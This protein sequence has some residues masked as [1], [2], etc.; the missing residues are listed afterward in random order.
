[1]VLEATLSVANEKTDRLDKRII[2]EDNVIVAEADVTQLGSL[3][4]RWLPTAGRETPTVRSV[5]VLAAEGTHDVYDYA[6]QSPGPDD[7]E[8]RRL[9]VHRILPHLDLVRPPLDELRH[10]HKT[11]DGKSYLISYWQRSHGGRRYVV[12]AWHSVPHVVHDLFPRMLE[13]T[14]GSARVHVVDEEGRTVFGQPTAGGEFTVGVPFQTTLYGWRLHATLTTAEELGVSVERRRRLEMIMVAASFLLVVAGVVIVVVAADRERRLAALKSELVANVSHE[15]KTPLSLVRMFSELLSSDRVLSETK[16]RQY[17]SII[18]R[19]SERLSAL[20]ENV[21]D[22]ARLERGEA[23]YIFEEASL[24]DVVTRAV[25][26]HRYRAE[27]E[28]MDISLEVAPNLPNTLLDERAIELALANLVD[29]AV[30]Y[31][32]SGKRI[33]VKVGVRGGRALEI[34]TTDYG[35]GIPQDEQRRIFD[36]FVRGRGA[37]NQQVRGSGIGLAL[38]QHIARAHGGQVWVHSRV[39]EGATFVFSIPLRT[40]KHF[41]GTRQLPPS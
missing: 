37:R 30:K 3:A 10:L 1:S 7:D 6:S 26:A 31:A 22:F 21:L 20:I 18:T 13:D 16:R 23:A 27:R 28:G 33:D 24:A 39:G 9:L 8:F 36:R 2:E 32:K 40:S 34:R 4:R 19:E 25:E 11:F 14:T 29:N 41:P 15:L 38:V 12:A 17:L 5:M 35:P